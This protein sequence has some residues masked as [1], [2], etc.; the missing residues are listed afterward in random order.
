MSD[1][2]PSGPNDGI[3]DLDVRVSKVDSCSD[4]HIPGSRVGGLLGQRCR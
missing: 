4:A 1:D 2:L 3:F